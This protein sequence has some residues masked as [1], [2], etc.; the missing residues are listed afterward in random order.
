MTTTALHLR[1]YN[2][3]VGD[4]LDLALAQPHQVLLST[5]SV[6]LMAQFAAH[7]GIVDP[8]VGYCIAGGVEWAYLRG[9]A[10]NAKAPTRWA[11]VLNWSA[12]AIVVLWGVLW[13]ATKYEAID[14]TAEGAAWWMALAHVVPVAWLSLCAAMTHSAAARA[15][16]AERKA[17]E[18]R[19]LARQERQ[20]QAADALAL[21]AERKRQD[22]A[23]W[24]E[25]QRLKIELSA[26]MPTE[27]SK[28]QNALM[29]APEGINAKVLACPNC[30]TT[31]DSPA[32]FGAAK[33]WKHCK[34]CKEA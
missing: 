1:I 8:L 27:M 28:L 33:R 5:G 15:E 21:E 34:A 10:S 32:E 11:A 9:L 14:P 31:L 18:A 16:V 24:A 4:V 19:A 6:A 12:F 2:A 22:L 7:G 23:L 26:V 29:P 25:G 17:Q 3:T 30:G 20:Q 13:V